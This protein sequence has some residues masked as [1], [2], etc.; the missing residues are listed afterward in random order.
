KELVKRPASVHAG[1]TR[2]RLA[3]T[4]AP[5]RA[6]TADSDQ[7]VAYTNGWDTVAAITYT[8]VNKAIKAYATYPKT[9]SH[10]ADDKSVAASGTFTGWSLTTGGAGPL[11]PIQLAIE[12][13][14]L[15]PDGEAT[16]PFSG[17]MV[18]QVNST[19]VPQQGK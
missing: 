17:T 4:A 8:E 12:D 13:G 15:T 2:I 19:F 3:M 1:R 16:K 11:V 7:G 5:T 6:A 18:V 10:E 14:K 9:F